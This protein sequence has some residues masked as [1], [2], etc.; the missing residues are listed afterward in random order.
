[1]ANLYRLVDRLAEPTRAEEPSRERVAGTVR[2][3]D[4]GRL[5]LADGVDLGR[6][7][8][9][10]RRRRVARDD[11]RRGSLGDDDEAGGARVLLRELGELAGN[12]RNVLGLPGRLLAGLKTKP[13]ERNIDSR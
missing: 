2:V 12:R 6:L 4:L 9:A 11:G 1:M 10:E 8:E 3:D 7:G 5:E 13:H